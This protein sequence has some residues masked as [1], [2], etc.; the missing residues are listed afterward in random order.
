VLRKTSVAL[1]IL[2][3]AGG[4][5]WGEGGWG[6]GRKVFDGVRRIQEK[7]KRPHQAARNIDTLQF[8]PNNPRMK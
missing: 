7:D 6:I 8:L 4:F 1:H 2:S 5:G 3:L